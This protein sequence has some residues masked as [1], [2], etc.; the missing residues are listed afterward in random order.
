[1]MVAVRYT[2]GKVLGSAPIG[3][4]TDASAY[5][6]GLRLAFASCNDGTITAVG[7]VAPEKFNAV[8]K[9]VT[10]PGA[11]TMTLDQSTHN[12]YTVTAK[13]G[14][15]AKATAA[16]PHPLPFPTVLPDTF[17]L[18]IYKRGS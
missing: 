14:P 2:D 1:M 10:E 12:L 11:R 13:F 5:D 3:K 4:G 9:I 8:Q 17:V 18:L 6:A 7:E 15:P 16:N